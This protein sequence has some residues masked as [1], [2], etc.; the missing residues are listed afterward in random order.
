MTI[1]TSEIPIDVTYIIVWGERWCV[2]VIPIRCVAT[3]G[4]K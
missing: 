1:M 2:T 4:T 3:I